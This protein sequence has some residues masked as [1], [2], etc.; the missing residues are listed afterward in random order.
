LVHM[1][2]F[3]VWSIF[4]PCSS[5]MHI[6]Y[7]FFCFCPPTCVKLEKATFNRPL[8]GSISKFYLCKEMKIQHHKVKRVH[9]LN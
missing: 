8:N 7:N 1:H 6:F 5:C 2:I 9:L 3:H 4:L